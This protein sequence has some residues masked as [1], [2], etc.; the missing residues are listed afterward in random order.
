MISGWFVFE[1]KKCST[2]INFEASLIV[3]IS[4]RCTINIILLYHR[5]NQNRLERN[6]G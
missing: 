5:R 2:I 4:F 3:E 1:A 6:L